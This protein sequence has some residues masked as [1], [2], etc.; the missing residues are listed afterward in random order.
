MYTELSCGCVPYKKDSNGNLLVLL[1]LRDKGYW[2]FPKGKK[3][4]EEDDITTALR[5]LE[6]ETGLVG[7]VTSHEPIEIQY[8][9]TR[10]GETVYKTSR[11]YVCSIPSDREVVIDGEEVVQYEWVRP[12]EAIAKIDREEMKDGAREAKKRLL[13]LCD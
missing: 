3:E 9:F 1:V 6:E 7:T 8:T 11:L 5:E 12:D 2:E 13:E 10:H 4:G